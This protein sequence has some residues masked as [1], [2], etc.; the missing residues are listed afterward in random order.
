[1]DDPRFWELMDK[2][3]AVNNKLAALG[4]GTSSTP[5]L[6]QPLE[7]LALYER[8]AS[9]LLRVLAMPSIKSGSYDYENEAELVY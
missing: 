3:V 5:A 1:M 8:M 4:N 6:L 7:K 2:M 9:L